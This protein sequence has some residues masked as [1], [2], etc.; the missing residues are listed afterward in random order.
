MAIAD[1]ITG[2]FGTF[3][4]VNMIPTRGFSVNV[5]ISLVLYHP[6][7]GPSKKLHVLEGPSKK[8]HVLEGQT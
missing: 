4:T 2:G 6:I 7:E 5:F 8:L 1:I 3:S